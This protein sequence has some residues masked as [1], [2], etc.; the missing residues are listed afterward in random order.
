[1]EEDE[2]RRVENARSRYLSKTRFHRIA[3]ATCGPRCS[4]H[5]EE[6]T[7]GGGDTNVTV[8]SE[9]HSRRV[10]EQESRSVEEQWSRRFV[11]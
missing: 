9:M 4:Q 7:S 11:E 5:G 3:P 6:N 2:S 10:E 1:M 8:N